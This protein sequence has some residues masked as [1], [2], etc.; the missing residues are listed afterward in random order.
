MGNIE[1][2]G[3]REDEGWV[4]EDGEP[5]IL[6][7]GEEVPVSDYNKERDE[8]KAIFMFRVGSAT[9]TKR[10]ITEEKFKSEVQVTSDDSW[11]L[12]ERTKSV[13]YKDSR[14][15]NLD[16]LKSYFESED[17]SSDED[18][19]EEEEL[20]CSI[21]NHTAEKVVAKQSQVAV[22]KEDGTKSTEPSGGEIE[23]K[24]V[25][26]NQTMET[27][28]LSKNKEAPVEL[29]DKVNPNVIGA[30]SDDSGP[31]MGGNREENTH[32][33]GARRA[34]V[35]AEDLVSP[36]QSIIC[37]ELVR[38]I[39]DVDTWG[40]CIADLKKYNSKVYKFTNPTSSNILAYKL[41]HIVQG[42]PYDV[43][44]ALNN[45]TERKSW[46]SS[47]KDVESHSIEGCKSTD[48]LHSR[49]KNWLIPSFD[50]VDFRRTWHDVPLFNEAGVEKK[51]IVVGFLDADGHPQGKPP[52]SGFNRC[53]SKRPSGMIF[54]DWEL[55]DSPGKQYTRITYFTVNSTTGIPP[56]AF[57]ADSNTVA[58]CKAFRKGLDAHMKKKLK[59]K[60]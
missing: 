48:V 24:N 42:S 56:P 8:D 28:A 6:L 30:T 16:R 19:A 45:V 54:E 44:E 43:N 41:V 40:S 47:Y 39:L 31:K 10:A 7:D 46:D 35:V 29:G 50:F 21:N 52:E 26:S 36:V 12:P 55:P 5:L 32:K 49:F 27:K 58:S 33:R 53:H 15:L 1:C 51:V 59:R 57:V 38:A 20:N 2:F 3:E 11:V 22:I 18:D 34:S 13:V 37:E 14:Q 25:L 60:K 17:S 23:M 4:E 9:L